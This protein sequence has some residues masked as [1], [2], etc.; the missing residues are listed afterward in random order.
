[1]ARRYSERLPFCRHEHDRAEQLT[2]GAGQSL[3]SAPFLAT[4]KLNGRTNTCGRRNII[5]LACCCDFS[6][7]G[8]VCNRVN[9]ALHPHCS[10]L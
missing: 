1:L 6:R 4:V 3:F 8:G 7:F 2:S 5:G 9:Q 10:R